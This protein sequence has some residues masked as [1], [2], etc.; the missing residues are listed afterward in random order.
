MNLTT[1]KNYNHYPLNNYKKTKTLNNTL[2]AGKKIND[3]DN[4][5]ALIC[6]HKFVFF[7]AIIAGIIAVIAA[8]LVVA[9]FT[10]TT[11]I[12]NKGAMTLDQMSMATLLWF[13]LNLILWE[14][15]IV[16]IPT[17]I[18]FGVGGYLWWN[19]LDDK[20]KKKFKDNNDKS[21]S[22][23]ITF[24]LFIAY[25]IYL[26]IDGNFYTPFGDLPLSYWITSYLWAAVWLGIIAGIPMTI[27]GILWLVNEKQCQ[28]K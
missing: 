2:M 12:I 25:V 5:K 26:F 13:A 8:G 3:K 28:V 24:F 6:E 19:S 15:L 11:D 16:G 18:T 20:Q 4:I 23:G 22:N 7:A 27:I 10:N 21:N 17:G 1:K 14:L 9:W